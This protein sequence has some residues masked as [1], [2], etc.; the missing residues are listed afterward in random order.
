MAVFKKTELVLDHVFD[1]STSR[2]YLNGQLS[3]LHCHHYSALYSQLAE[4]ISFL[5]GRKL[6][7]DVAGETFYK[8]LDEYYRGHGIQA[9]K[10]KVTIA[11]QYYAAIGLGSMKTIY[12]GPDS[13]EVELKHSHVDEGWI[14]KWGTH[15]KPINF[16]T[17]GFIGAVVCLL[18]A[19]PLGSYEVLETQSIVCGEK[20]SRFKIVT[21]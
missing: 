15:D 18:N 7:S 17:Q 13:A 20:V 14:K 8:C 21:R 6:L 1:P 9:F 2:H 4:D 11:E 16:I 3:V 10:D 5:D 12:V 19:K